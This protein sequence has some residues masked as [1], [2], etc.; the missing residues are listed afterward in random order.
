MAVSIGASGA[1]C[2]NVQQALDAIAGDNVTTFRQ[3]RPGALEAIRSPVNTAMGQTE[4]LNVQD[5]GGK[6][7][8]NQVSYWT[9]PRTASATSAPNICEAGTTTGQ[10]FADVTTNITRS[11]TLTLDEAEFR[12]FCGD[13][14]KNSQ[15]AQQQVKA[16]VDQLLVDID[17]DVINFLS[18]GYG[19]F[20]NG[21]VGPI[22]LPL[23]TP[24]YA[25]QYGGEVT[26][27]NALEDAEVPGKPIV[28]GQ[29]YLRDYVRLKAIA[30]CNDDGVDISRSTDSF[31]YYRDARLDQTMAG[32]NNIIAWQ[33]GAAQMISKT[34]FVGEYARLFDPDKI[35]TTVTIRLGEIDLPVDFTLY[36]DYCGD[37]KGV[38]KYVMTWT[39]RFGFFSL[40]TDLEPVGSPFRSV[41]NI[42]YFTASCG[43]TTCSDVDS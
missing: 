12:F 39:A 37:G 3:I 32:S 23:I 6:T 40:P 30:C 27:M 36:Y 18:T 34:T 17:Q 21:I 1:C 11:Q 38:S 20:A 22:N 29:G 15:F 42:F 10:K 8:T 7:R 2:L 35:K 28:V 26:M 4:Q 13:G 19:Q 5:P 14:V 24:S 9:N 31:Y 16:K 41:N 33:P 43:T 25:P